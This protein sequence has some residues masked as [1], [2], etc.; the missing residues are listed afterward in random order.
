MTLARY[1]SRRARR[2][3][4]HRVLAAG[5]LGPGPCAAGSGMLLHCFEKANILKIARTGHL[6]IVLTPTS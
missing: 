3:A 6:K 5:G 2:R 4:A 1:R